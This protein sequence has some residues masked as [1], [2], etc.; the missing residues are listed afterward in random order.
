MWLRCCTSLGTTT[1]PRFCHGVSQTQLVLQEKDALIASRNKAITQ[2]MNMMRNQEERLQHLQE[3]VE[4]REVANQES[5][6]RQC[7]AMMHCV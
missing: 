3:V 6:V 5:V 2:A 1:L 7:H 4:L